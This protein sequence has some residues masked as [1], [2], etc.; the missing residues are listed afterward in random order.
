MRT[1]RG[2]RGPSGGVDV[3]VAGDDGVPRALE[4]RLDLRNHS[5]T[6]FEWGYGGSGPSQLALA[7][8]SDHFGADVRTNVGR[9]LAD[10]KALE[11]Y[12]DFKFACVAALPSDGWQLT[13]D[14]IVAAVRALGGRHG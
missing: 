1:Y 6:G 10:V 2:T 8:L 9:G 14:H 7:I 11:L 12:Q 5:Q 4:P 13:T 3:T